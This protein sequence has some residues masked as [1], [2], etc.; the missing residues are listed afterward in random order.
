M[1]IAPFCGAAAV[2]VE[3]LAGRDLGLPVADVLDRERVAV[4]PLRDAEDEPA[5]VP[6]RHG[7]HLA[8][9]RAVLVGEPGDHGRHAGDVESSR[10]VVTL[11]GAPGRRR[12]S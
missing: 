1:E 12:D 6:A 4:E 10:P 2:L 8:V 3:V 5:D 7:E 11:A 9:Q